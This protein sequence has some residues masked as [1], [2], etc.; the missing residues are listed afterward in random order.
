[1]RVVILFLLC[2][3]MSLLASDVHAVDIEK[4]R[5][6]PAPD[7]T[8]LVFDLDKPIRHNIFTLDKPDRLVIDLDNVV[9]KASVR[10]LSVKDTP[11]RRIRTGIK[12]GSDMRIVFDLNHKVQPRSFLLKPNKQYGHRLVVDLI[13]KDKKTSDKSS[14]PATQPVETPP[15]SASSR[16]E[17]S[18][19]SA[20]NQDQRPGGI[21]S[22][23]KGKR[24][25]IIAVDAGHGGEDPGAIGPGGVREKTVVLAIAK[26][27]QALLNKEQGFKPVMI[28]TGDYYVGLR[29]RSER[30]R[31]YRADLLIS[32]H[33]DAFKDSRPRGSS[34]FAL[35]QR[36]ATSETARWL[37]NSENSADL[38]GG[39]S[40]AL[41]LDDKDKVLAGVLLD[42]SMQATLSDSLKVGQKVLRAM[43]K[44]N[45]LHKRDVEQAGFM[46]L[47][48]PDIPSILIETGFISNPREAKNLQS[49]AYQSKMA[50]QI[51]QG[52]KEYF[53]NN[54]PAGTLLAWE[55]EQNGQ[56]SYV[57]ARGDTLSEIAQRNKIS[58]NS[59]RKANNLRSDKVFVGQRLRIPRS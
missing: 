51:T 33:A 17:P 46:V 40:G 11:I 44:I 55:K 15:V 19:A 48:S 54:P 13:Y 14:A 37:A 43:G 28:R 30:A 23:P 26:K 12:R 18:T 27:I 22:N 4:V 58:V 25:I 9:D 3:L 35:S 45:K 7:H 34:V 57:V 53:R 32:I 10:K 20:S 8:R 21:K 59:L 5:I 49:Q 16:S 24:S 38:I 36:G 50:R 6:W 1:M 42:L 41:T 56:K 39:V 29:A 2:S 47:K 31:K 52:I